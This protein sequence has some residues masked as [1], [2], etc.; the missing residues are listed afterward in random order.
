LAAT[1]EGLLETSQRYWRE[2]VIVDDGSIHPVSY[3]HPE[4]IILR[5][6]EAAGVCPSRRQ[7]LAAASGNVFVTLDPHMTFEP[8]WLD[9]MLEHVDSR[10]LLC[11]RW[12][13]YERTTT[14]CWGA[15]FAWARP[16][17][18]GFMHV[19]R[20]GPPGRSAVDVP[21]VLG[22]CYMM[23]RDA[24]EEMGGFCPLFRIWGK[25][26]PDLS[27]RAWLGGFG[28]KC[29]ASAGV[30]HLSRKFPFPV[31][32]DHTLFNEVVMMR[33]VFEKETASLL[34]EYLAPLSEEI[35][36]WLRQADVAGWRELV[37]SR[38]RISDAEFFHRY[39]RQVPLSFKNG[40]SPKRGH[41]PRSRVRAAVEQ[42]EQ[43][44]ALTL[45][46]INSPVVIG[47]PRDA[48]LPAFSGGIPALINQDREM[49][50][51][52]ALPWL[53]GTAFRS[54][55]V[56]IG[57]RV[58]CGNFLQEI[59]TSLPPHREILDSGEVDVLYSLIV[60][61]GTP[62]RYRLYA[63]PGF[64]C[65]T[66]ALGRLR[67]ALETAIENDIAVHTTQ[68]L[69]VRAGVV[70]WRGRALVLP[71]DRLHGIRPLVAE[72]VRAGAGYYSSSYAVF[73]HE[74]RVHPFAK[75][76]E[77]AGCAGS[78][79]DG[80]ADSSGGEARLPPLRV[81]W[82]ASIGYRPGARQQ[83]RST[84]SGK[85]LLALMQNSLFVEDQQGQA[86]GLL[87]KALRGASGFQGTR[88][89]A[90]SMAQAL[91]GCADAS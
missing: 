45:G 67:S 26:E 31:T 24:Y 90:R 14:Y 83:L 84:T 57:I 21:M 9:R 41:V 49:S 88:G 42:E 52:D 64:I 2:I 23:R 81:G 29:V 72:L 30:G 1:I 33:T 44:L 18:P 61:P 28:V 74:G 56:R 34:E 78:M 70:A 5:N 53:C 35:Q 89:N 22:A 43:E 54:F 3:P 11:A 68:Y 55:G 60:E 36:A 73:D 47:P 17:H 82:V 80:L 79:F 65:D 10:A 48:T 13:D 39:A 71:G 40:V 63:G 75:P 86:F 76:F 16:P 37:Q 38:R 19:G 15:D 46:K 77:L 69:L 8:D 62:L 51:L 91:L 85:T 12:M 59:A 32:W 50:E 7:A 4:V 58:N 25:D 66:A 87:S 6:A 20:S 27:A